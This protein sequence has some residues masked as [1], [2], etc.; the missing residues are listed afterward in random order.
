MNKSQIA[1]DFFLQGLNCSQSVAA[2]F[3]EEMGLDEDFVKRLTLGF[4]GGMGRM[5][6]V[7]G[8]VSGMTFVLSAVYKNDD[9]K[10]MY[11]R[12]Q[13]VGRRFKEENGSVVC[14]ELLGLTEK[15]EI[16]PVPQ[17][18]TQQYYKKRPC[19]S[20]VG[21]GASILQEYLKNHPF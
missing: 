17:P 16:S 10:T 4:G 14:R 19:K 20:L 5:R 7:C 18:R 3:C 9:K 12:V 13:E 8:V 15:D 11:G 2:A 6:E 1:E 21:M